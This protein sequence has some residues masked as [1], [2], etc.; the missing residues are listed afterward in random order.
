MSEEDELLCV[1]SLFDDV[2][3]SPLTKKLAKQE[4]TA[5][6]DNSGAVLPVPL[7][8][9]NISLSKNT[10]PALESRLSELKVELLE[11]M[12]NREKQLIYLHHEIEKEKIKF[13][14][15]EK[16]LQREQIAVV[17]ALT[18]AQSTPQ[19]EAKLEEALCGVCIESV[20][21]TLL[22]PCGHTAL[23]FGCA[24]A[25]SKSKNPEC[26]YCRRRITGVYKC[27]LV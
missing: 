8:R 27:F 10:I 17:S 12:A 21:D 2:E 5:L 1:G 15:L 6:P 9:R 4:Q 23:C 16:R 14:E 11:A 19:S 24:E 22:A 13:S 25:I 26:P 7:L 3:P 18:K 20:R